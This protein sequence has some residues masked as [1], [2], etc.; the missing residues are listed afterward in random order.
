MAKRLNTL[1][2][3]WC[4]VTKE[5]SY[6]VLAEGPGL[7]TEMETSHFNLV[8]DLENVSDVTASHCI[9]YLLRI[10]KWMEASYLFAVSRFCFDASYI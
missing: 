1:S 2:W 3:F 6:F 9:P 5:N 8:L 10:Q 7:P 4:E